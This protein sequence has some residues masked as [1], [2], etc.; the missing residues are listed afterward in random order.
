MPDSESESLNMVLPFQ[1]KT[2]FEQDTEISVQEKVQ[3]Y[4]QMPSAPQFKS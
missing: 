1:I 3:E 4:K 2:A